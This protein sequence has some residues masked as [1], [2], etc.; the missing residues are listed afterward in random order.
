MLNQYA[1]EPG[2]QVPPALAAL[3]A[4]GTPVCVTAV[5]DGHGHG[6]HAASKAAELTL[7]HLVENIHLMDTLSE[8]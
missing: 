7:P 5:F 4:A 8:Y 1:L 3:Q 6:E 2:S